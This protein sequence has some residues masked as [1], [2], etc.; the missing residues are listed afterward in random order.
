MELKNR[1]DDRFEGEDSDHVWYA[2]CSNYCL[3]YSFKKVSQITDVWN[4]GDMRGWDGCE[5][6]STSRLMQKTGD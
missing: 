2:M 3:E 1:N 5:E 4:G 6:S